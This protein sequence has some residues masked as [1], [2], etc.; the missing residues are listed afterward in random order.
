MSVS[1]NLFREKFHFD[2]IAVPCLAIAPLGS[3]LGQRWT[4]ATGSHRRGGA[5]MK[6]FADF[7]LF[8][9]R[10]CDIAQTGAAELWAKGYQFEAISC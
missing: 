1:I 5:E 9:A 2:L 7:M 4:T 6:F 8:L 3:R 10:Y